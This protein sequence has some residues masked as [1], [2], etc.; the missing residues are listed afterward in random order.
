MEWAAARGAVRWKGPSDYSIGQQQLQ[1]LPP[2]VFTSHPAP[3]TSLGGVW[4]WG[5]GGTCSPLSLFP[6]SVPA[7]L[8][9]RQRRLS[10]SSYICVAL[11]S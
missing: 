2:P 5:F 9:L 7:F 8:L 11:C 1:R 3:G 6:P 4:V 10:L